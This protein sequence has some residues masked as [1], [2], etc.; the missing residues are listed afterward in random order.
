MQEEKPMNKKLSGITRKIKETR[1]L[2]DLGSK[3]RIGL[4]KTGLGPA[5]NIAPDSFGEQLVLLFA[6]GQ[7][8]PLFCFSIE[9]TLYAVVEQEKVSQCSQKLLN[10]SAV[11]VWMKAGW[12]SATAS[13]VPES[14][15]EDLTEKMKDLSVYG[16]VGA[17]LGG[18]TSQTHRVIL[19]KLNGARTGEKGPGQYSW[20]WAAAA[21]YFFASSLKRK[22]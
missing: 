5:L 13:L 16:K 3:T 9:E 1:I 15:M 19:I 12:Y 21:L 18:E 17:W 14:S 6:D 8:L 7:K 11:E 2:A 22:K 10:S 20:I 4:W